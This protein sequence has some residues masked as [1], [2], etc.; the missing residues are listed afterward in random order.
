MMR[1]IFKFLTLGIFAC[2]LSSCTSS[3]Y[4]S[5]PKT[6][7][8]ELLVGND[9]DENGCKNSAGFTWSE[10][11]QKCIRVFEIG[12]RVTATFEHDSTFTFYVVSGKEANRKELFTSKGAVVLNDKNGQ[13]MND[14]WLLKKAGKEWTLEKR[15]G[16]K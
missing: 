15:L 6:T 8:P 14:H 1:L 7:P 16:E 2:T 13:W 4:S 10:L 11:L 9:K 12:E 3:D 5:P